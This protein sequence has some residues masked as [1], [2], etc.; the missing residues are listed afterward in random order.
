[1]LFRSLDG[2]PQEYYSFSSALRT[3]DDPIG[4]EQVYVLLTFEEKSLRHASEL[5]KDL[6]HMAMIG[7]GPRPNSSPPTFNG[8][9]HK[10]T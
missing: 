4:Y 1:M 8:H 6:V 2:L 5:I 9:F 3:R 10:T 7:Q